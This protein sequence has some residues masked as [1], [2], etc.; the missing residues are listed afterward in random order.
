T[1]LSQL[2]TALSAAAAD[3]PAA[4]ERLK[5][6]TRNAAKE[7]QRLREELADYHAA[8]LAVEVPIE[9]NLRIVDRTWKDRDPEYCKLLASRLTK[10]APS[11]I[12]LF[13]TEVAE[14]AFVV[15]S[16]SLDFNFECGRILRESLAQLGLRGGGSPD[17]AQG[18]VPVQQLS[19]LRTAILGAVQK[20]VSESR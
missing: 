2:T 15:L 6:D 16:R 1:I 14:T 17:F 18:E 5:A 11:T 7:R 13:C 8:R 10:A 20:S 12:V 4:V 9:Y 3:V 19:A